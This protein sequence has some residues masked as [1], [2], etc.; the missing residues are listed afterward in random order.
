P[1]APQPMPPTSSVV[2]GSDAPTALPAAT[3]APSPNDT[4][5]VP[6]TIDVHSDCTDSVPLFLGDKPKFG[7][8][9]KTS[10]SSN[11][12]TS[13]PRDSDGTLTIWII[14]DQENGLASVHITKR[15]KKVEI[16]RSCRT[17]DAH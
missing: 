14:D 5:M 7:S 10:V 16:G 3:S 12:T 15:M 17:L 11:S 6:L 8:G 1:S 13:F 2:A 9:T 4:T